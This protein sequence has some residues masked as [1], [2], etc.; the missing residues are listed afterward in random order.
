[1]VVRFARCHII[2]C[3]GV[4]PVSFTVNSGGTLRRRGGRIG[5][6]LRYDTAPDDKDA[7]MDAVIS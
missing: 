2:Q 7:S 5:C 6:G 4:N 1:M 3:W